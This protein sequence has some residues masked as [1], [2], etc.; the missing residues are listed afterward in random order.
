MWSLSRRTMAN[1]VAQLKNNNNEVAA[2]RTS[3]NEVTTQKNNDK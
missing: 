1:D 3:T 2:T